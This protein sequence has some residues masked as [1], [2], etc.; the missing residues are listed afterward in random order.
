SR[1][2]GRHPREA[3]LTDRSSFIRYLKGVICSLVEGLWRSYENR[4]TFVSLESETLG[5]GGL[6][7]HESAPGEDLAQQPFA[8]LPKK[9]PRRLLPTIRQWAAHWR[10]C[11][12]IPLAGKHRR[13]RQELRALAIKVLKEVSHGSLDIQAECQ[14]RINHE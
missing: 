13:H 4:F 5:A 10:E 1:R 6:T 12:V 8:K 9:A 11:E 14:L 2:H 3:D 7:S